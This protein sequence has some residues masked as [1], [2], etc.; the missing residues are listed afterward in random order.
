MEGGED[1]SPTTGSNNALVLGHRCAARATLAAMSLARVLVADDHPLFRAAVLH[2]LREEIEVGQTLEVASVS[3][4]TEALAVHPDVDL[5]L[6]DLTM[7][8]ARGFS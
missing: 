2:A 6:L 8:G 3:A 5:V 1:N 7:P 4:L